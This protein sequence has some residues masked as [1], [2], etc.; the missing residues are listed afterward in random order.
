[1]RYVRAPIVVD[2]ADGRPCFARQHG[3]KAVA[4][5]NRLPKAHECG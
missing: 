1:M 4:G 2:P 3:K 5:A